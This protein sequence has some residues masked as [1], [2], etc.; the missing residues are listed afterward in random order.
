VSVMPKKVVKQRGSKTHGWGSKKKHR[1]AGSRGGR[2][3]AGI[4]KHKKL[5]FR[6]RGVQVGSSGHK[7]MKQRGLRARTKSINL[8]EL[9]NLS[10][11]KKEIILREF[12]YDKVIGAGSIKSPLKVIARAFSA[13]AVEKIEAAKGKAVKDE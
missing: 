8:R 7:S 13:R 2:G 10:Q 9:E 4:T 5:Y 12:G 3:R 11:G 6:K 1:G